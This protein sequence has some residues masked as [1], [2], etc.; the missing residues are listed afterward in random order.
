MTVARDQKDEDM[1]ERTRSKAIVQHGEK[2]VVEEATLPE[3]KEHEI[4]IRVHHAALNPT[5]GMLRL[6]AFSRRLLTDPLVLAFDLEAFGDG[7]I[8]GCDFAGTVEALGPD[9][10]KFSVGDKVA[11]FIW[12]GK[13]RR[14]A[15]PEQ[16]DYMEGQN[17]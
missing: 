12:G 7:A 13:A 1:P 3:V 10:T 6:R 5:D 14:V 16:S 17:G 9:A 2:L 11:S 8:L 15:T 4:L